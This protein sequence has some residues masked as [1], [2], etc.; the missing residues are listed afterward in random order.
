MKKSLIAVLAAFLAI[1][2]VAAP[3]AVAKKKKKKPPAPVVVTFVEE[4][5]ITAPAP[6]GAASKGVTEAEF[7][8]ANE[9]ASMPA[10][11]GF[12]GH[13]VELPEDFR[14]GTATLEV[15]GSDASGQYDLDVYFY[16][17]GCSL[18]EP[19]M[20]DGADATGPIPGGAT[21][22]VIDLF[23]GANASFKLTATTT[24]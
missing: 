13:V 8:I 9:C 11:Q 22:A 10:S 2:L 20:T 15:L 6:S 5:T 16:D 7:T 14:T 19:Y 1:G 12:D 24:K 23:V 18:M 21:W 3:S 4:G 17:A